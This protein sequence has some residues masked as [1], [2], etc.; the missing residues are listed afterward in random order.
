MKSASNLVILGDWGTSACRLYLCRFHQQQL[1]VVA[2]TQGRGIKH[3]N[4]PEARFFELAQA[5]F[6]QFGAIPVF[7]IGT[8][9]ADI[10]WRQAPYVYCPT[11]KKNMLSAAIKFQARDI[12]FTILPGLSC[13]NRHDLPDIMR[14]EETQLFGFLSQQGNSTKK[15]LICLPGTHTKWALLK[16][17]SIE[18]F[19]TSPVG[20]LFEVLCHHSVLLS[21]SDHKSWC[22]ESFTHGIQ[23]GMRKTSNLL[24]T[25]FAT[26]AY[27]IIDKHN[28]TQ[29]AGYLSG[30]L[31]GA[32]VKAAMD[33][34]H[35]FSHVTVIGSDHIC[36][37]YV[38]ALKHIGITTEQFSSEDAT[39]LGLQALASDSWKDHAAA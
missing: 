35:L 27:Q 16:E 21:P 10:G 28:N 25:L 24:H 6:E 7:L 31:V 20:E 1:S 26:R 32:D 19:V 2:R 9:G 18:S 5:W 12:D 34:F 29:A 14:G 13:K 11:N 39:L 8:V 23:V 36:S 38:E 33:D 3:G 4:D 15:R 22:T 37:L 30:L 17:Q